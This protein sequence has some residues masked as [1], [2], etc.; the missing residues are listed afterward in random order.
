MA[1]WI[2]S[3]FFALLLVAATYAF[4]LSCVRVSEALDLFLSL[5]P[6][7][8][9]P[10]VHLLGALGLVAL[11]AGLAAALLRPAWVCLC[12]FLLSSLALFVALGP[13]ARS[14][15]MA[16]LYLVAALLYARGVI[17]GLDQR[18]RFSVQP[19]SQSQSVLALA[20][21]LLAGASFY[22]PYAAKVDRE[23]F[24][25]PAQAMEEVVKVIEAQIEAR[26]PEMPP[27]EREMFLSQFQEQM[28]GQIMDFLKPYERYIPLAVALGLAWPLWTVYTL[29]SW[30]PG[31]VL[32]L[33][34]PLLTLVRFVRV[35]TETK[36][37]SWLTLG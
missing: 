4:G 29:L 20:L 25:V 35:A 19:I 27:D 18:L 21:V 16:L 37:A 6:E 12:G 32:R 23:G 10:I 5:S 3:A 14:G 22:F 9:A 17:T 13:G 24:S 28:E 15:A 36:E 1:K 7:A 34:F 26:A 33:V 30:L 11:T 31:L 8:L 2:K